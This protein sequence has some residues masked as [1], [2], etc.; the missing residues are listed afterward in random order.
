MADNAKP[1]RLEETAGCHAC[2][3]HGLDAGVQIAHPAGDGNRG[4]EIV[5]K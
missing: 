5:M 1:G 4:S 2:G 3:L